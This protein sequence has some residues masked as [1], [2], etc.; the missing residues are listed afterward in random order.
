MQGS[1]G[2]AENGTYGDS[3]YEAG[4]RATDEPERPGDPKGLALQALTALLH[5]ARFSSFLR[6]FFGGAAALLGAQR[7]A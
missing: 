6:I 7:P 4:D 2:R 3:D 5:A 1:T